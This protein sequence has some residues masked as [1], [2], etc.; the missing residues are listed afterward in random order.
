[1]VLQDFMIRTSICTW[2]RRHTRRY[3]IIASSIFR[4]Q[5]KSNRHECSFSFFNSM[6]RKPR[7]SMSWEVDDDNVVEIHKS[8]VRRILTRKLRL[9]GIGV[10]STWW[11]ARFCRAA[12]IVVIIVFSIL[13]VWECRSHKFDHAAKYLSFDQV[14]TPPSSWKKAWFL[15]VNCGTICFHFLCLL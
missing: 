1:M 7:S 2:E 9:G 3:L 12:T 6:M 4:L 8:H 5:L 10:V 15:V 13:W 14:L 11:W